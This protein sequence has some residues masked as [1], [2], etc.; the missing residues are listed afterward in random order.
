[1]PVKV[2]VEIADPFVK[3]VQVLGE[4]SASNHFLLSDTAL[5]FISSP[6]SKPYRALDQFLRVLFEVPQDPDVVVDT[7]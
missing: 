7:K 2:F 3:V 4:H 5:Q 1:M 6:A